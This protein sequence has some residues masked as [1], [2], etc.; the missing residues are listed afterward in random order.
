MTTI[1]RIIEHFGL[2]V[3]HYGFQPGETPKEAD[4]RRAV[5]IGPAAGLIL[6]TAQVAIALEAQEPAERDQT[7]TAVVGRTMAWVNGAL[8]MREGMFDDDPGPGASVSI[9]VA[10]LVVTDRMNPRRLTTL[11]CQVTP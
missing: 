3:A 11:L 2:T 1:Q 5:G 9:A 6:T 10:A 7:A 4:L 8:M